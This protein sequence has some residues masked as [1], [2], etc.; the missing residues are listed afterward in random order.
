MRH[1]LLAGS[2]VS[3]VLALLLGCTGDTPSPTAQA[4]TGA[5]QGQGDQWSADQWQATD[6]ILADRVERLAIAGEIDA[7]Q[8]VFA[9]LAARPSIVGAPAEQRAHLALARALVG[10]QRNDEALRH[11]TAINWA[12]KSSEIASQVLALQARV[13][14]QQLT[15]NGEIISGAIPAMA[16][17]EAPQGVPGGVWLARR[18]AYA[19]LAEVLDR[20]MRLVQVEG[21][22]PQLPA[23]REQLTLARYA[24]GDRTR[25]ELA[26]ELGTPA[27]WSPALLLAVV[28]VHLLEHEIDD[29]AVLA[30]WLWDHHS[31][32]PEASA[33][34]GQFR[35]WQLLRE[36]A[37]TQL[38]VWA[39]P[40]LEARLLTLIE[41]YPAAEKMAR[42]ELA[43]QQDVNAQALVPVSD[44]KNR[45]IRPQERAIK[46]A[47]E[48][49]EEPAEVLQAVAEATQETTENRAF[50]LAD[51]WPGLQISLGART[52]PASSSAQVHI[53]SEH[54]GEH[55]L[56]VWKLADAAAYTALTANPA[57]ARLPATALLER[58]VTVA[59]WPSLGERFSVSTA[60]GLLSEGFYAV[61]VTARGCPV[62]VVQGFV[63]CDSDLHTIASASA[64]VAWVVD[65]GD[66]CSKK[67]EPLR[68]DLSLV[69]DP[70]RAAGAAWAP[71]NPAW[72]AGFRAAYLG[73]K[74]AAWQ[75]AGEAQDFSTGGVAGT[76]AALRDPAH[77]VVLTAVSDAQ[78]L[79]R[80][81]VPEKFIGRDW[82]ATVTIDRPQI[83]VVAHPEHRAAGP[84]SAVHLAWADKP[85]VRP[86]ETVRFKA[87]L[88]D[89]DGEA[90]HRPEGT[91]QVE[92]FCGSSRL[93]SGE[94]SVSDVGTVAG[95][96]IIPPGCADG[97]LRLAMEQDR[98]VVAGIPTTETLASSQTIAVV[99]SYALPPGSLT[100]VDDG[101]N[102]LRAGET[103]N[104]RVQVHDAAGV[105]LANVP[106]EVSTKVVDLA[107]GQSVPAS[108]DNVR[109]DSTGEVI[110]RIASPRDAEQ[111]LVATCKATI[112]GQRFSAT[113]S[114]TTRRFPVPM[115]VELAQ[116]NVPVGGFLRARVRLPLGAIVEAFVVRDGQ[117]LSPAVTVQGNGGWSEV[118]IGLS[119]ATLGA[120]ALRFT[121]DQLGGGKASR[122]VV[123]T[124]WSAA[125]TVDSPVRCVA[126][127]TTVLPGSVVHLTVGTTHPGRDVLIL[128]GTSEILLTHVVHLADPALTVELPV[129][130][131][132]APN[133]S[134]KTL[135][136]LPGRGFTESA[137]QAISVLPVDRLLTVV[138]QPDRLEYRVNGTALLTLSVTDW[139]QQ[140]VAGASLSVGLVDERLYGL[141]ED[142]TPDLVEWFTAKNRTW[143]LSEQSARGLA[144]LS[145]ELWRAVAR[146]W[147]V[148][149]ASMAIGAGG[150]GG[151]KYGCVSAGGRRQ[152]FV[153]TVLPESDSAIHWSA[154]LRTAANGQA[155]VRIQLP[156]TP[157]RFRITAR[158]NDASA[159]VLV[160][161]VRGEVVIREP[162]TCIA[163]GPQQAVDGDVIPLTVDV[164]SR[165]PTDVPL[166]TRVHAQGDPTVL[167]HQVISL[168]AGMRRSLNLPVALRLPNTGEIR[169]VGDVLG[170]AVRLVVEVTTPSDATPVCTQH[171]VLLAMP[172][173]PVV[174]AVQLVADST[175]NIPTILAPAGSAVWLRLRAWPDAAARRRSELLA[176]RTAPG[177]RGALAWLLAEDGQL[178]SDELARRWLT[179]GTDA[180]ADYVRLVAR[181]LGSLEH[182]ELTNQTTASGAWLSAY[183]RTL[184]M[185]FARPKLSK[186]ETQSE[187]FAQA[188]IDLR[189]GVSGAGR[190]WLIAQRQVLA[191]S[192]SL[193]LAFALD[194]AVVSGNTTLTRQLQAQLAIRD[195]PDEFTAV[196]VVD[197][198]PSVGTPVSPRCTL[199]PGSEPVALQGTEWTVWSGVTSTDL[200]LT[201]SPGALIAADVVVQAVSLAE[202]APVRLFRR[203]QEEL[204]DERVL[205]V[206]LSPTAP[207]EVGEQLVL[208]VPGSEPYMLPALFQ[209]AS[210][211]QSGTRV[212]SIEYTWA[213]AP[214]NALASN[215]NIVSRFATMS[216]V[217]TLV[218]V[219]I[220][221]EGADQLRLFTSHR[222]VQPGY[223]LV[224]V[225]GPGTC[226]LARAKPGADRLSVLTE[227]PEVVPETL[228]FPLLTEVQ[229]RYV[230]CEPAEQAIFTDGQ[231]R[232]LFDWQSLLNLC[233]PTVTSELSFDQLIQHP[234]CGQRGHRTTQALRK[235]ITTEPDFDT[236]QADEMFSSQYNLS[237]VVQIVQ[238]S[239]EKRRRAIVYQP[240]PRPLETAQPHSLREW[241]S[242]Y[243]ELGLLDIHHTQGI[244]DW[245]WRQSLTREDFLTMGYG[246]TAEEWVR[247]LRTEF[248]FQ[249][250]LGR[251]VPGGIAMDDDVGDQRDAPAGGQLGF[252]HL[253][254][255]GMELVALPDGLE[256]RTTNAGDTLK[257]SIAVTDVPLAGVIDRLN[258][259]LVARGVAE[260]LYDP[261]AEDIAIT[262]K[263]RDMKPRLLLACLMKLSGCTLENE[264]T[265]IRVIASKP[266]P[267]E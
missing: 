188:A 97:P 121:A 103:R 247:F 254:A 90:W 98:P 260:V 26:T 224:E 62:V 22:T 30:T 169:R 82:K 77:S 31:A 58:S 49:A 65:R 262:L 137:L 138:A 75:G 15:R 55:M 79:A 159:A 213:L 20:G 109:T 43:E 3:C 19:A 67:G 145:A 165:L 23:S 7:S 218:G 263:V 163:H 21:G 267:I 239:R 233:D 151:G 179:L 9:T 252:E 11:L 94:L 243:R 216:G 1:V 47:E 36:R 57:R 133:L 118:T 190:R 99:K 214:I 123:I 181:R 81:S 52:I 178:R 106:I 136:W 88:R 108:G 134:F 196:L 146:R 4:H 202:Q 89:W 201:A 51:T 110:V 53:A 172:G 46:L 258:K 16:S 100:I 189:E 209:L 78:G 250:R 135:G 48:P 198:L 183:G 251:G 164:S 215:E 33:A 180:A 161:E 167:A 83:A 185:P 140:P 13:R 266:I 219:N 42:A 259:Q 12:D 199:H 127:A 14:W 143:S 129:A 160:G 115:T 139:K 158:A 113:S 144:V 68:A 193:A 245:F 222:M 2:A 93:F 131:N 107:S 225:R 261:P 173:V 157:G 192:D 186:I 148:V 229:M 265:Q 253:A 205:L 45:E 59:P 41:Q 154:D 211:S 217:R 242:R 122:D 40:E 124:V 50:I 153:G 232:S 70:A 119:P 120:T 166:T 207:L 174:N 230:Q 257:V 54:R 44:Q 128:G 142:L 264:G 86:G 18:S 25:A 111:A 117:L 132:W 240:F 37:A 74:E 91:A 150:G 200:R 149:G 176:W 182:L 17:A 226:S 80:W 95:E 69:R 204:Q 223:V 27:T 244:E 248:G 234:L 6:Q 203:D 38:S 210:N 156:A 8:G 241:A 237:E 227:L 194:A 212:T 126:R 168:G 141:G 231:P 61:T 171:E 162:L 112:A 76:A 34:F 101:C 87:L 195:W 175:G 236:L 85:V 114:W 28:R 66:G 238:E 60:V 32:T 35:G 92:I 170:R 39:F 56:R 191:D 208:Q 63:V 5:N 73:L 96:I 10:L 130:A 116:R 228:V 256:V 221:A 184:G 29:A 177:A 255:A 155:T 147:Q 152:A 249:V 197:Q 105:P 64:L 187:V 125:A 71:A 84:W 72:Q 206:E 246:Q 102:D 104:L 235:W 24:Y 220:D